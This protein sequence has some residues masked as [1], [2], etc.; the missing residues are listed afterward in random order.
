MG[1]NSALRVLRE[2]VSSVM[3]RVHKHVSLT[4]LVP[5]C[6]DAENASP[7]EETVASI[8]RA[9]KIGLGTT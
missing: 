6:S 4:F 1:F 5:K 3:D 8:D 2:Q 7:L 9:A